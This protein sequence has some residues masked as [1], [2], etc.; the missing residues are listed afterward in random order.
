MS[1][2]LALG[3]LALAPQHCGGPCEVPRGADPVCPNPVFKLVMGKR[4]A[5]WAY[6]FN[7]EWAEDGEVRKNLYGVFSTPPL[8]QAGFRS[9]KFLPPWLWYQ[10]R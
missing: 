1:A 9:W 6:L 5:N 8:I 7:W 2:T 3:L 4:R 10:S